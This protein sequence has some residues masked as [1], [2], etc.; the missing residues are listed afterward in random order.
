MP[1]SDLINIFVEILSNTNEKKML[2][3]H[4]DQGSQLRHDEQTRK[5]KE[6]IVYMY[7]LLE[8]SCDNRTF[9]DKDIVFF[10]SELN[11]DVK[12]SEV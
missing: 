7:S 1:K 11:E 4:Q 6:D 3:S 10:Y 5:S 8:G 9:Q 12:S 2:A